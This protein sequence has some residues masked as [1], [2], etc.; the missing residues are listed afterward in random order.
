MAGR[1]YNKEILIAFISNRNH[2]FDPSEC[3]REFCRLSTVKR[4]YNDVD[5]VGQQQQREEPIHFHGIGHHDTGS[6]HFKDTGQCVAFYLQ[7][8]RF[9]SAHPTVNYFNHF[10]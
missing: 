7:R 4:A 1:I 8:K 3:T 6:E 2:E 5:K 10:F 9:V